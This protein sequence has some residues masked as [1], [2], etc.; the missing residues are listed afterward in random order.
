MFFAFC[1]SFDLYV[2]S[3][4]IVKGDMKVGCYCNHINGNILLFFHLVLNF[5]ESEF[6]LVHNGLQIGKSTMDPPPMALIP[7]VQ[8]RQSFN[9][10]I[11]FQLYIR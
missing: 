7:K 3:F 9:E 8:N 6:P 5:V 4:L 10:I 1:L 11:S 2:N